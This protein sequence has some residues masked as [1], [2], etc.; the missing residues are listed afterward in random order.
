MSSFARATACDTD[1]LPHES[2]AFACRVALVK[3][4]LF[5]HI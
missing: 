1:G 5:S 3:L 4:A 2:E